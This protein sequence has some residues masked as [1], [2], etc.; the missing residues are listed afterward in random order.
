MR[1]AQPPPDWQSDS[2][3]CG[4]SLEHVRV[5]FDPSRPH[6]T[7]AE[8]TFASQDATHLLVVYLAGHMMPGGSASPSAADPATGSRFCAGIRALPNVRAKPVQ[9][10][11]AAKL[12]SPLV[13]RV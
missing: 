8:I 10:R 4:I 3:L 7:G 12:R 9:A 6:A 5:L 1:R 11:A 13:S 2:R